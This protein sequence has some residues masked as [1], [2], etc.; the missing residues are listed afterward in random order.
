MFTSHSS[1]SP[2]SM[3]LGSFGSCEMVRGEQ[4][5]RSRSD[6]MELKGPHRTSSDLERKANSPHLLRIALCYRYEKE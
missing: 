6:M 3:S 5:G 1:K 4:N 2:V